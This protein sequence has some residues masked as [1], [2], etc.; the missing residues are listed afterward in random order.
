[1]NDRDRR[2][3][4]NGKEGERERKAQKE[5]ERNER[6]KSCSSR[7]FFIV[8]KQQRVE[9]IAISIATNKK[10]AKKNET[11]SLCKTEG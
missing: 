9:V 1:M 6:T 7:T 11:A 5:N 2:E 4:E 10:N 8:T 3:N